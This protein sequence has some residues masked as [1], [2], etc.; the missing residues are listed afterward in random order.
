MSRFNAILL[1][2]LALL[3]VPAFSA[4]PPKGTTTAPQTSPVDVAD[5][6]PA[7][8]LARTTVVKP[9]VE[10]A[11]LNAP[12]PRA[13]LAAR[14][15][16]AL[17]LPTSSQLLGRLADAVRQG[18]S[19]AAEV[20]GRD[21]PPVN[22][23]AIDNETTGLPD[24]CRAAQAAGAVLIVGGI[25]RD[26]AT[27]LAK[28]D[29]TRQPVL[30]LNEPQA[31]PAELPPNLYMASLSLENEARQVA[32]M[33]VAD[34]LHSAVIITSASPLA[35]RV[36]E[37]FER[38]WTRDAGQT[39]GRITFTGGADDAPLIREK[40]AGVNADMVF[41]ALDP[42]E[43]RVVRPYVSAVLPLYATSMSVNPR[44]EAIVNLD[45]QGM[46]YME[47]PWFVQPDHPAVMVY[48][49]PKG[50][51]IEE[52]RLYAFGIDAYRIAVQLLRGDKAATIDG[53][54]G[55]LTLEGPSQFNRTLTPAEF[56]GGRAI[57]LRT[58]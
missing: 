49:V 47:M 3:A 31:T 41:M 37:A 1:A 51:P 13:P 56:D 53:V 4:D 24:A 43:A 34:G 30:A 6:D 10:V 20:A 35:R 21:G 57:P 44:A 48:P 39:V 27:A 12:A 18:F 29:C 28:G 52:E 14:A 50:M 23:T 16:I 7:T 38:E 40:L 17:I 54:T 22:V 9:L 33:A 26:G 58:P 2:V 32:L 45:L 8:G 5:I 11:P 36:Q 19:A 25:T 15:H 55:K 42:P 46:R